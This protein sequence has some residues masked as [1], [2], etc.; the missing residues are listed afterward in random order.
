MK[1]NRMKK[2]KTFL[3][4]DDN[5]F[6]GWEH[7]NCC[8]HWNHFNL[9]GDDQKQSHSTYLH[10][11]WSLLWDELYKFERYDS[12]RWIKMLQNAWDPICWM[13][14][15]FFVLF[16]SFSAFF[17]LWMCLYCLLPVQKVFV[18]S[19]FTV[20]QSLLHFNTHA[21]LNSS[22]DNFNMVV[23]NLWQK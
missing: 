20:F 9:D 6:F 21:H 5:T 23:S 12:Q 19:T 11:E 2:K 18:N 22:T 13:R 16:I 8:N 10:F 1:W 3:S 17:F 14:I 4:L 15:F 7:N